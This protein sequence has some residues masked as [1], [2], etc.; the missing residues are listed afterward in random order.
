ML[1]YKTIRAGRDTMYACLTFDSTLMSELERIQK[2][3]AE[4]MALG[5]KSSAA[6]IQRLRPAI[7]EARS[8]GFSHRAIH[9]SLSSGGLSTSWTNYR[10]ALGRASKAS[11]PASG[12]SSKGQGPGTPAMPSRQELPTPPRAKQ[13]GE[14]R[15]PS[16]TASATRVLDALVEARKVA[17]SR[18]YAQIARDLHRQKRNQQ[19]KDLP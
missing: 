9:N 1:F 18:D 16:G 3:T 14:K 2:H 12:T 5:L 8:A 7:T 10:I 11:A 15:T 17:S 6:V 19:R 4:L 13:L